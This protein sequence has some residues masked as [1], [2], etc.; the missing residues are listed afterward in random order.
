MSE[1]LKVLIVDDST[2]MRLVAK[3]QVGSLGH[4]V[5]A[6]AEDGKV[7]LQKYL[8]HKPDVVLLD[9]VMPRFDGKKTLKKLLQL[10]P[11]AN[12]IICSSLG[13]EA[14]IEFCLSNGARSYLQKPYEAEGIQNALQSIAV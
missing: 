13:S 4:H 3:V 14:D 1:K 10:D 9:L 2:S 6:E 8:E 11:N 7:A 12:V 5:I